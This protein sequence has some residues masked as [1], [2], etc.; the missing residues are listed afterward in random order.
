MQLKL[1]INACQISMWLCMGG[2]RSAVLACLSQSLHVWLDTSK[3]PGC[4]IYWLFKSL[5][6]WLLHTET[7]QAEIQAGAKAYIHMTYCKHELAQVC[8]VAVQ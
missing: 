6:P 3:I 1:T 4:M 7:I 5:K 8:F 2:L